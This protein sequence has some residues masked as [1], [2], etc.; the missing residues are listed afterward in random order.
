MSHSALLYAS[1]ITVRIGRRAAVVEYLIMCIHRSSCT[2]H[3]IKTYAKM[4]LFPL[5]RAQIQ[6]NT[7]NFAGQRFS[8]HGVD[9]TKFDGGGARDQEVFTWMPH[10]L[11]LIYR[12]VYRDVS[13]A[14]Q[15]F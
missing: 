14:I 12:S 8:L 7:G 2:W 4:A 6:A 3:T 10:T 15:L 11:G 5:E 13:S 9:L 1:H